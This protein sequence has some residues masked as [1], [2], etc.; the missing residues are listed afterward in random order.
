MELVVELTGSK[1]PIE[2]YPDAA[3]VN[4]KRFQIEVRKLKL[5]ALQ[6]LNHMTNSVADPEKRV[7]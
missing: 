5:S 6:E 3:R 4:L 2:T 7:G 1:Y